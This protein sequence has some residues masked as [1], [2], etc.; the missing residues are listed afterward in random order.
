MN[1]IVER[2]SNLQNSIS[3]NTNIFNC[4]RMQFPNLPFFLSAVDFPNVV[5]P[6][7]TALLG[8]LVPDKIVLFILNLLIQF[9]FTMHMG[10]FVSMYVC[11]PP[12]CLVP[13]EVGRGFQLE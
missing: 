9:N 11:S 3:Y 5:I 12:A 8:S 4:L 6:W 7:S 1:S 2:L 13:V 10:V